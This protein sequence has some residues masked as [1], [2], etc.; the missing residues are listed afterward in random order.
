VVQI[1]SPRP[2]LCNQQLM[3]R[4]TSLCKT[5]RSDRAIAS[6]LANLCC[7]EGIYGI[8]F[9]TTSVFVLRDRDTTALS[10]DRR[11]VSTA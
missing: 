3:D 6:D 9:R 4:Q 7:P 5:K 11:T 1:H 10:G 8:A 2:I